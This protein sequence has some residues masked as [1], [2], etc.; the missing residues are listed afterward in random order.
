MPTDVDKTASAC[1]RKDKTSQRAKGDLIG[2]TVATN[3]LI[4]TLPKALP[5][6]DP[7][8]RLAGMDFVLQT[9]S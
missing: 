6:R 5:T 3:L 7:Q 9:T 4:H 2:G 8:L 1:S